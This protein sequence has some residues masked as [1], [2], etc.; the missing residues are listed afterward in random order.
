[1]AV[2][3]GTL[4]AQG[5][6]VK[7]SVS[8][9]GLMGNVVGD[10]PVR[11]T[12]VYLP[13]SYQ[14][15]LTRRYPVLYLLH[16][17]TSVPDEWVDGTY[18]GFDLRVAMDSLAAA[19]TIPELIVVMP[20]ADNALGAGFYANSTTTGNW[21]AFVVQDLVRHVDRRYRT[22]ARTSKRA[23]VGHSM[24]GSARSTW[25][26]II[27]TSSG[28]STRSAR[29]ASASSGAPGHPGR[30]PRSGRSNAG[31]MRRATCGSC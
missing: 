2:L 18:E 31:R 23:L 22:D 5:T 25:A 20:N 12:L 21:E 8:S 1:V 28:S 19:G 30:G 16:G 14:R 29:A 15:D 10:S 4:G 13:P 6:I 27:P 3:S 17:A 24:G 7:D 9:P 11:R 26:S